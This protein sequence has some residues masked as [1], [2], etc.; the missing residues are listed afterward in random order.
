MSNL[1]FNANNGSPVISDQG[2]ALD[3]TQ[4]ATDRQYAPGTRLIHNDGREFVYV[5][6]TAAIAAG[7]PVQVTDVLSLLVDADVDAAAAIGSDTLTGTGDFTSIT[8]AQLA[9]AAVYI[10]VDPG[11]GQHRFVKQRIDDDTIRVTEA[12]DVA[13][14]TSSDYVIYRPW[15]VEPKAATALPAR[16]IAQVAIASGSFGWV[17]TQGLGN[18]LVD[19]SQDPLIAGEIVAVGTAVAGTAQGRTAAA[20]AAADLGS[21]LGTAVIDVVTDDL[22]PIYINVGHGSL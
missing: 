20:L 16:G 8:A 3:A 9:F 1:Q 2:V 14:T 11:A 7:N 19:T 5:E 13:L 17:Q 4:T 12:W 18:V 22:A 21:S 15:A 6:A 10:N